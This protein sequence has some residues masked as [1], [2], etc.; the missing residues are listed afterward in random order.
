MVEVLL[1]K[2]TLQGQNL[3]R[4]I[5][6]ICI[7]DSPLKVV[8]DRNLK[9]EACISLAKDSWPK[10]LPAKL[11]ELHGPHLASRGSADR[12]VTLLLCMWEGPKA[13][14]LRPGPAF[15]LRPRPPNSHFPPPPLWP[16]AHHGLFTLPSV[17]PC[18]FW[19]GVTVIVISEQDRPRLRLSST[20]NDC[21]TEGRRNLPYLFSS[22]SV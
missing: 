11:T 9:I 6:A 10:G 5:F 3:I 8:L 18:H 17:K 4:D 7:P 19:V 13:V 14:T 2:Q 15:H 12:S 21:N 20:G 1:F 16:L 22:F